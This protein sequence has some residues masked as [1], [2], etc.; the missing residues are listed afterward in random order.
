[1]RLR[2][3]GDEVSR[4]VSHLSFGPKVAGSADATALDSRIAVPLTHTFNID[5]RHL[6][7]QT[8][9]LAEQQLRDCTRRDETVFK[10]K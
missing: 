10:N 4:L 7:D 9:L 6:Q 2:R 1:M 8:E 5:L 3:A